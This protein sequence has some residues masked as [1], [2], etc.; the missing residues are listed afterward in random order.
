MIGFTLLMETAMLMIPLARFLTRRF[1]R[2]TNVVI[3]L[4]HTVAVNFFY[5]IGGVPKGFTWYTIFVIVETACTVLIMILALERNCKSA[6]KPTSELAS[7][8]N[9]LKTKN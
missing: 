7:Q 5:L 1:N 4:L 9:S 2:W 3:A 6:G 8:S